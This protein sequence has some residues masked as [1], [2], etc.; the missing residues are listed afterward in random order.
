[1]PRSCAGDV[2]SGEWVSPE[3]FLCFIPGLP[4]SRG[5]LQGQLFLLFGNGAGLMGHL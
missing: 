1:M 4:N 3:Y 5:D 2:A